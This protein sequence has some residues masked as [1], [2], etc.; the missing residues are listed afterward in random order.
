MDL[1]DLSVFRQAVVT[2]TAPS[3]P[4]SVERDRDARK[5]RHYQLS[6]E[7]IVN[8]NSGYQYWT[9]I[10]D[11]THSTYIKYTRDEIQFARLN[12]LGETSSL[13]NT[14]EIN[15]DLVIMVLGVQYGMQQ[16]DNSPDQSNILLHNIFQVDDKLGN[17]TCW[18]TDTIL[19]IVG[20]FQWSAVGYTA[21]LLPHAETSSSVQGHT[22][23][24]QQL[25]L[26]P[27]IRRHLQKDDDSHNDVYKIV[28]SVSISCNDAW[29]QTLQ[30]EEA[31]PKVCH[32]VNVVETAAL[33]KAWL[34]DGALVITGATTALVQKRNVNRCPYRTF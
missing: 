34:S 8:R 23:S 32:N 3:L 16:V 10:C 28:I 30:K 25:N 12:S 4:D 33:D 6:R 19:K 26:R 27:L 14:G 15:V 9:T 20:D 21:E 24:H 22:V 1:V 11:A 2:P 29:Q 5:L 7:V 31:N 18:W 13:L 17:T